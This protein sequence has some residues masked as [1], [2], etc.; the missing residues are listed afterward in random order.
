MHSSNQNIFVD[1]NERYLSF[2]FAN[3]KHLS[4]KIGTTKSVECKI[5]IRVYQKV[6][7]LSK[8]FL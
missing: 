7:K 3:P 6:Q 5:R 8:S 1:L 2:F 4:R